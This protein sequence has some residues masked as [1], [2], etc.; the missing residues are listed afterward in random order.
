M[1]DRLFL[2]PTSLDAPDAAR[3]KAALEAANDAFFEVDLGDRTI[4]WSRGITLLFGH[5][6][7][8]RGQRLADW[9]DLI[10]PEDMRVV[11]E[12]GRQLLLPRKHAWSHEFRFARADAT[13]APVRVRAFLIADQS[14]SP[15]HVV[16]TLTD[17]GPIRQ[18]EEELRSV[19]AELSERL[20]RERFERVRA[21]VFM[22][23]TSA[24]VLA[25]WR[26]DT[27]GM[28]WSPN[29]ERVLGYP[30]SELG[31]ITDLARRAPD[32]ARDLDDV[33]A[34]LA[35]GATAWSRHV[36]W[37]LPSGADVM[38]E[39]HAYVLRDRDG[40]PERVVGSF[41]RVAAAPGQPERGPTPELTERQREVLSFVRLGYT[42]KEIAQALTISEQAAKVQVRKLMGKFGAQN[43]AALAARAASTGALS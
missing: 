7:A 10:H 17:L 29:V 41:C 12:S 3:L 6:P 27:D 23:A 20:A 43:R 22:R 28:V 16:G 4:R 1:P 15:A 21:E 30:A 32:I 11:A 31:T 42:N 5:D 13:Y 34:R 18:L 8:R 24:D 35:A 2:D 26:L 38:V 36:R 14:G 39:A 40:R 9:Q 33:R 37:L 25:E 19:T